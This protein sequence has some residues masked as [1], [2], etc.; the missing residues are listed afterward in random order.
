[1]NSFWLLLFII[2]LYSRINIF[3]FQNWNY[4]SNVK[5]IDHSRLQVWI[6]EFF[7]GKSGSCLQIAYFFPFILFKFPPPPPPLLCCY[8]ILP[9]VPTLLLIRT[10]PFIP[11]PIVDQMCRQTFF[12]LSGT[13]GLLKGYTINFQNQLLHICGKL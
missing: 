9:N 1:M 3:K 11:D 7:N 4:Y 13:E 2:K 10:S 5:N 8:F 12:K 6:W